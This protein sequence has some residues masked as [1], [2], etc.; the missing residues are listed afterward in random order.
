M[1]KKKL[2][3]TQAKKLIK[4]SLDNLRPLMEDRLLQID[5]NVPITID[6]FRKLRQPLKRAFN[7]L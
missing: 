2:T 7:K 5:S 1:P 6:S 3:K 4:R